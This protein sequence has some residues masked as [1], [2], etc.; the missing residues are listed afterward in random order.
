MEVLVLVLFVLNFMMSIYRG[1]ADSW[2]NGWV[3]ATFGWASAIVCQI[4]IMSML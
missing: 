2:S 4:Q 1:F 3:G